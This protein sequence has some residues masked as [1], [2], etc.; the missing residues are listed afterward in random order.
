LVQPNTGIDIVHEV[1][2]ITFLWVLWVLWE[3]WERGRFGGAPPNSP[4]FRP[5]LNGGGKGET[6]FFEDYTP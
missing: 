2:G 5:K 3:S 4:F 6:P 1:R